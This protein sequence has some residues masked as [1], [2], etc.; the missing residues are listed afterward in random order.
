MNVITVGQFLELDPADA[1]LSRQDLTP[2]R[3][4]QWQSE[5][6]LV[7]QVGL[8]PADA[9][10]LVGCGITDPEVLAMADVDH[11]HRHIHSCLASAEAQGRYSPASRLDRRTL[12]NWIEMARRSLHP[13]RSHLGQRFTP[14]RQTNLAVRP[15]QHDASSSPKADHFDAE[16]RQPRRFGRDVR[17][18][19]R[20]AGST[21]SRP[22]RARS[23]TA[24]PAKSL[25]AESLRFYLEPADSIGDAPSIGPKTAERFRAIGVST[26]AQFIEADP[27]LMA[28]RIAYPR[29]TAD[30]VREW[31]LQARLVTRV[32]NLRGPDAQILVACGAT[33][34]EELATM[35]ADRLFRQV[36]KF[37]GTTEGKR[38]LRNGTR[39]NQVEVASWI[40]WAQS[41]REVSNQPSASTGRSLA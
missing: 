37:C 8:A 15:Q 17:R 3:I 25:Q 31:Q 30:V 26:I 32:P 9:V 2:D 5:M 41:G 40:R 21:E 13:R 1:R 23:S 28:D 20:A 39:P 35:D 10:V 34:P 22:S 18:T 6:S 27:V 7:A 16:S 36:K 12:A 11:L 19:V 29:I 24:T 14:R 4:R 38:I 33:T